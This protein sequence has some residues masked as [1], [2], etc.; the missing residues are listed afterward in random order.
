[1]TK[2]SA[3][4]HLLPLAIGLVAFATAVPIELGTQAWTIDFGV[5]DFLANIVLYAPLGLALSKH[6]PLAVAVVGFAASG[7]IEL[8]Q[9]WSVSRNPSPFDVLANTGGTLL[10]AAVG[11]GALGFGEWRRFLSI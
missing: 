4:L 7:V 6:R 11:R 2:D 3:D 5:V 9:I 8:S 1:M 10:G